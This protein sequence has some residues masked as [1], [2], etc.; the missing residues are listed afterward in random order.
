MGEYRMPSLGADMEA[1]TLRSWRIAVGDPVKKGQVVGEVETDKGIID[2][3]IWDEG[4]VQSILVQPGGKVPV[5]TVLAIVGA[6]GAALPTAAV[7]S[8]PSRAAAR[9]G[10]DLR[11]SPAARQRARELGVD[12]AKATATGPHGS[13]TRD[14]VDR[15]AREAAPPPAPSTPPP[16][17]AE[18]APPADRQAALRRAIA[19]AMARSK[20]EIP[21]YYVSTT[22]DVTAS[23][24]WLAAYNAAR[25]PSE[26]VLLAALLLRATARTLVQFPELNGFHYDGVFHPSPHVHVGVGIALRGGGLVAPAIHD[27]ESKPVA[28]IMSDLRDLVG[29]ARGGTLRSSELVDPTVTMTNLGEQGVETVFGVIYPPQVAIVGFGKVVERPF[30]KDGMVGVHPLVTASLAADHRV[31]DGH[32]GGLF[33]AALARAL[34]EAKHE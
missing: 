34:E 6:A 15:A 25:P 16:A 21:H 23:Q 27:A 8:P 28:Q 11:A 26:R 29:R 14:D 17:P 3:E 19:A 33:L 5:G 31:S 30:A 22:I 7:A 24:Q 20:R 1:G 9:A 4:I 32:R 2:L 10:T 13:I 12:L 18:A